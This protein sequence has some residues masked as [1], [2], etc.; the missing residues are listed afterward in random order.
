MHFEYPGWL[1]LLLVLVPV[2]W[3]SRGARTTLGPVRGIV[4]PL[5]RCM[6]VAAL[7]LALAN[8]VL[9]LRSDRL[10]VAV[11]LDRSRSMSDQE[12][13]RAVQWLQAATAAR[14]EDDLLAVV[15]AAEDASAVLMPDPHGQ[16]GVEPLQSS[17]AGTDLAGAIE[18]TKGLLPKD[19]RH[20]IL[21]VSDGNETRGSIAE[22]ADRAGEAGIPIDVLPIVYHRA[23][24]VMVERLMAPTEIRSNEPTD[25]RV[26]LRA[27]SPT[28]GTLHLLSEGVP[29]S[30]RIP[31]QLEAGT[32]VVPL[33]VPPGN[34]AM[35]RYEAVFEPAAD[36]G[37]RTLGNNAASAVTLQVGR[38]RV[39][40]VSNGGPGAA[41]FTDV[42]SDRGLAVES[43]GV[44]AIFGGPPALAAW[45]AIVLADVPRWSIPDRL[46]GEL[47][48][49]VRVGGGGLLMTGG[50]TSL[51]AGGWIGS[52][53]AGVLPLGLDPPADRQVRRGALAIILHSCE[54]P[55]GNA[56][57]RRVAEAAIEALSSV[58]MIGLLEYDNRQGG[59]RW[60][61][62]MQQAGNKRAALHAAA[63][64]KYGDMP[65]FAEAM[66]D[67]LE[68][69]MGVDAGQRH[70][71][72][73]SD[74]DPQPP[75]DDLLDQ[76]VQA[77]VSVTT[78]MVGGH[79]TP[80]DRRR[81]AAVASITGGRFHDVVDA[82]QLPQIFCQEAQVVS[83]S[84]IQKGSFA[85]GWTGPGGGP[86]TGGDM[87]AIGP[88]PPVH[89]YVLTESLG[90]L[91]QDTMV[92]AGSN[93][94]DP[95]LAWRSAGL[96]R[97]AAFT[98]EVGGPWTAD[99]ADW[100]GAGPLWERTMGWLLR[101]G[102]EGLLAMQLREGDDGEV[103]VDL[104]AVA[105]DFANFLQTEAVVMGP[106]GGGGHVPLQQ[107]GPGRYRGVFQMDQPG[108]WV[109]GVK[110]RGVDPRTNE[111][112]EGWVQGATV[113]NWS[114]EDAAVRSNATL[115]ADVARRSGG[116]VLSMRNDPAQAVVFERT[117][118][119]ATAGQRSIWAMLAIAAAVLLLLDVAVRRIVPDRQR[120]A[121]L[122]RRAAEASAGVARSAES[123]WKRA[124][125]G[126]RAGAHQKDPPPSTE[127]AR[128]E[129]P[130]K[131]D[132][133]EAAGDTMSRLRAARKRLRDE[134][135][136]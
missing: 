97:T 54:M 75:G 14:G 60:A 132:E 124:R 112:V 127:Q 99:W 61:L 69:V 20:R 39:L 16:V 98:S 135:H 100:Q 123:A 22:A 3:R 119:V 13:D 94:S 37:D 90:G 95:L 125:A 50:S 103:V 10:T 110:Y 43:A 111:P 82:T 58:D 23:G 121:V 126:A 102:D 101:P 122:A 68:G 136:Q 76:Y 18:F 35:Q 31:L 84:L 72:I 5:L 74:G 26:V 25:L 6:L 105:S 79:G 51:G 65:D 129:E 53:V 67:A 47:A 12:V 19:G 134:D 29:I 32:T 83:R 86:L 56:W 52:E 49:W 34:R 7:V 130:P 48:E 40:V 2:L 96:G 33:R 80:I 88:I 17:D 116:R 28:A 131:A 91:S 115:L 15:H 81:M 27:E 107:V 63:S 70:V 42:L 57:G 77:R 64:L 113:R 128:A 117:G 59:T 44:E 45:D 108:G 36:S 89:G 120:Q 55:Q 62:P 46:D 8:P 66:Q 4:V 92:V 41:Y 21:L 133:E 71:I 11:V 106:G 38:G 9:D 73:I 78:V 118:L 93:G 87:A 1:V 30:E 104:E 114:G 109:V 85:A 24:E